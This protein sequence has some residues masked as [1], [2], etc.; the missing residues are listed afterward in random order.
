MN[1]EQREG[2]VTIMTFI[3]APS[4]RA[5][6][7]GVLLTLTL[8][9]GWTDALC[10]LILDRVFASFMTGNL[11][12]VGLSLAQRNTALLVRAGVAGLVFLPRLTPRATFLPTRPGPP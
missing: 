10:Y 3:E 12:F 8:A 7:A 5:A 2:A 11:L 6:R 9:A 4:R 1:A